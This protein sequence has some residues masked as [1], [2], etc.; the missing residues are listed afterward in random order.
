MRRKADAFAEKLSG[1]YDLP[2]AEV[3]SHVLEL[4]GILTF[5]WT[6]EIAEVIRKRAR[7]REQ[8]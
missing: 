7:A 3:L 1:E 8:C 4:G 6:A 5:R 2:L